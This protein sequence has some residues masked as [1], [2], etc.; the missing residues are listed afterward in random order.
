MSWALAA[1]LMGYARHHHADLPAVTLA[2]EW[3]PTVRGLASE[4]SRGLFPGC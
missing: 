1:M 3:P 2:E 4:W